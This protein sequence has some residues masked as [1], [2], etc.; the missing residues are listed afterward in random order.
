[1]KSVATSLKLELSLFY[2]KFTF[3]WYGIEKA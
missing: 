2:E 1:M 3:K